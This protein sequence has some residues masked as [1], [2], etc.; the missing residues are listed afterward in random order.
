LTPM[1]GSAM[2]KVMASSRGLSASR[3]DERPVVDSAAKSRGRVPGTQDAA[4][5]FS[6]RSVSPGIVP[7]AAYHGCISTVR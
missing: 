7:Y 1:Q 3:L 5:Y 4:R 6:R 2:T